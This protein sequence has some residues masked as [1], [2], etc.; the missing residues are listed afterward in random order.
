MLTKIKLLENIVQNRDFLTI[1]TKIETFE[2]FNRKKFSKNLDQKRHFRKFWP[3][4]RFSKNFDQY[5]DCFEDFDQNQDF[6]IFF[7]EIMIFSKIL[8]KIK[9]IENFD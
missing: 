2:N 4:L 9:I 3:E 6:S 5:G 8:N 1:F 7:R